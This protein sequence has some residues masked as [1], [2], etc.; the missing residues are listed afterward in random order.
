MEVKMIK[1]ELQQ[2]LSELESE[3]A[4]LDNKQM[5]LKILINSEY[6]A[7]GNV[8]FRYYDLRLAT[9]VTL[10]GQLAIR[11]IENYLMEH[12]LQ[13][14]YKWNVIYI[15]TDSL[16]IDMKYVVSLI[17][18]ANPEISDARIVNKLD[19]FNNKIVQKIIDEG[20]QKMATYVNAPENF[21]NMKREKII[22]NLMIPTKKRYAMTVWDNE[23]VRYPEP[24]LS[25]TGLQSV[26]SSTPKPVRGYLKEAYHIILTDV[27]ELK[28]YM[29]EIKDKFNQIPVEEIATIKSCNNILKYTDE[30]TGL[31]VKRTPIQVRASIVYNNY[32]RDK[33]L[34]WKYPIIQEGEKIRYV[35]LRE[36]NVLHSNVVGFVRNIPDEIRQFVD[37]RT[38]YNKTFY[39]A[40]DNFIKICRTPINIKCEVDLNSLFKGD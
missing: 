4:T 36:P 15:D 38:M 31:W 22:S 5:A 10:S 12:E 26:S 16:Y 40:I 14:K 27:D 11:Y 6:G 3:I 17:K 33:K 7:L 25:V 34:E 29:R 9:A 30:K 23:G 20:Y 19:Q 1:E 24:R 21:M 39:K 8:F 37:Y 13:K 2:K 32:V 28:W 18:K 35:Y